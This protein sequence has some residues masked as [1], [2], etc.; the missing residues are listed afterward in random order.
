MRFRFPPECVSSGR[1]RSF[2]VPP[3]TPGAPTN[4]P[5]HCFSK[6]KDPLLYGSLFLNKMKMNTYIYEKCPIN[7]NV[8]PEIKLIWPF[9]LRGATATLRLCVLVDSKDANLCLSLLDLVSKPNVCLSKA[10]NG[11]TNTIFN[12]INVTFISRVPI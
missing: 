12:P 9:P 5:P 2:T 3:R 4:I 1:W 6:S 8:L 10:E 7:T 11:P